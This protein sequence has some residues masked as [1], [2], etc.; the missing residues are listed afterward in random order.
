MGEKIGLREGEREILH[1]LNGL[2]VKGIL[3]DLVVNK[4]ANT[5]ILSGSPYPTS[6]FFCVHAQK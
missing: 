4:L 5:K 1:I 2:M 3:A 6:T